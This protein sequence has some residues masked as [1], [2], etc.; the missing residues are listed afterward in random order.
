MSLP[1]KVGLA[2]VA[3]IF[4]IAIAIAWNLVSAMI[5]QA[6]TGIA[7][8]YG[9]G[10]GY[11]WKK[12]A[13]GERMNPGAITAAH[14]THKFNSMIAVCHRSTGRCITVRINDRGP[15]IRGRVIDLSP[16]AAAALGCDGLCPVTVQ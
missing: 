1:L 2:I 6:E 10:D 4:G 7:S 13:N 5:A 3:T 15:F 8:I 12:T 11:A 9:N 16:A 14:R